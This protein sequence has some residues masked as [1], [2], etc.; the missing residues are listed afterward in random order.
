MQNIRTHTDLTGQRFGRLT[1]IE[2]GPRTVTRGAR[3]LCACDC[4]SMK[5]HRGEHLKSGGSQ[6]CGCLRG[7]QFGDRNRKHGRSDAQLYS[8]WVNMKARCLQA[9]HA[10]YPYYGGRG[11]TVCDAWLNSF[12]QF[13]ADM[14]PRSSPAHSIERID[15]NGN[16]EPSNCKWATAKEQR[17][18][19]RPARR[20]V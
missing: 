15:N 16:Y 3:W 10:S 1:V 8:I 7:E 2:A 13:E 14:G 6:S 17:A 18:N 19:Q 20:I 12:D 5:L 9:Q 4:G 11:I